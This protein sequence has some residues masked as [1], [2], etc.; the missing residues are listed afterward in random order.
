MAGVGDS[1][2]LPATSEA[3]KAATREALCA[4]ESVRSR[5]SSPRLLGGGEGGWMI[6]SGRGEMPVASNI[7]K[8]A[9]SRIRATWQE[10]ALGPMVT[11]S[12]HW[13]LPKLS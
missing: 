11:H 4:I 10:K 5:A 9:G 3:A 2:T 1:L 6:W 7:F 8:P 12:S 13:G